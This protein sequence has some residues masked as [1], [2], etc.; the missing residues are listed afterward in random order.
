M[1]STERGPTRPGGRPASPRR[2]AAARRGPP[3]QPGARRAA[4]PRRAQPPPRPRP[5]PA[6][7][8]R[9]GPPGAGASDAG[10]RRAAAHPRRDRRRLGGPGARRG[11]GRRG[12][13]P[14]PGGGPARAPGGRPALDAYAAGCGWPLYGAARRGRARAGA[15]LRHRLDD[16]RRCRPPTTPR[17][18]RW[19]RSPSPT[20]RTSA[21]VRPENVNRVKV[22]LDKVPEHVRQ[23]VLA[24]EDSTFYS[25]PGLRHLRHRAG[26]LQPAHRRGRRRL[27]DHPAVREGGHRRARPHAV[28]QVQG[29]RARG[30]DL[31]GAAEGPDPGELPQLHLLRPRRLRHPGRR[32][33]LLRQERRATSPCPR[34]RCWPGI[35][36][37]PSSWDPAK[38]QADSQRRWTFVLDQM[39]DKKWLDP[40]ERAQQAFPDELAEG[41]AEAGRGARRRPLPHLQPGPGRAGGPGHHRGPDQHRGPGRDDHGGRGRA[42][43]GRAGDQEDACGG[44]PD[45]LRCGAGLGGPEDRRDPGLLRRLERPGH[46][47]RPGAAPA[48]VVVQA[49]RAGRRAAGRQGPERPRRRARLAPTTASPGRRSSTG[50]P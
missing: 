44:Q 9:A 30:Q 6:P 7:A 21:V 45:N 15:G 16:L 38:N 11:A 37:A 25:N 46:R 35:I 29:G 42:A 5:D 2:R 20:A 10:R 34:G 47:L 3:R 23:A 40:A 28:A 8:A 39:V 50:S 26:H 33:G 32:Q 13:R 4:P 48:R 27:D 14:R 18:P 19:P 41:A 24:A 22:T 36:Q 49:V 12:R 43:Q 1:I 17:S 31:Q